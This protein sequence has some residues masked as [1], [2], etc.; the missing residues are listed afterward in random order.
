MLTFDH[1]VVPATTLAEGI[2]AVEAALGVSLQ[3]GGQ[4]VRMGTHNRLL[5][6]GDI[7]LEVIAPDPGLP[8]PGRPRWFDMDRF[9]GPPRPTVWVCRCDDLGTE[10]ARSPAG[11]GTPIP[12]ERNGFSWTIAVPDD[13][14]LPFDNAY[15]AL[16][17][18]DPGSPRPGDR[19]TDVGVRLTR[20]TIATPHAEAL[21]AAL[22]GR[23]DAPRVTIA[24]A[25]APAMRA[26]FSTPFGPRQL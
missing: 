17:R 26:E 18:W 22:K 23:F 15:P 2:S 11:T 24:D 1:L 6:L 5:Q 20:L 19:L 10:L 14:I 12:M 7:Y 25:P 21:R 13:G 9:Q 4:H 8:P 3:G 16:I